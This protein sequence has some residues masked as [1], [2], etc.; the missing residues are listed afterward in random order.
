MLMKQ[1]IKVIAATA[2]ATV[3]SLLVSGAGFAATLTGTSPNTQTPIGGGGA[4][5]WYSAYAY[6]GQNNSLGQQFGVVWTAKNGQTATAGFEWTVNVYGN[7]LSSLTWLSTK[8]P[9]KNN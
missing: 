4:N 3:L 8:G 6:V 2:G 9:P 7:S 1:T 5:Y